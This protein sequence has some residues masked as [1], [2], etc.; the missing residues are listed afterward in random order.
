M[1]TV[2]FHMDKNEE[3]TVAFH[4]A[5]NLKKNQK[6]FDNFL[7]TSNAESMLGEVKIFYPT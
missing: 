2:L 6:I 4:F 5:N 1:G 7:M 3:A